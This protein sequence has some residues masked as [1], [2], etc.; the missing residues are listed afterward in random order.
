MVLDEAHRGIRSLFIGEARC[1]QPDTECASVGT[2]GAQGPDEG[3]E[4][5]TV[6]RTNSLCVSKAFPDVE[7]Q[8]WPQCEQLLPH[9]LVC[10]ELIEQYQLSST[11]A[12]YLLNQT[13]YLSQGTCSL[14]RSGTIVQASIG[15]REEQ[16]G[17]IAS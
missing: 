7:H 3:R 15:N 4:Q 12:A 1:D 2:S 8:N 10:S 11:E 13:G 16:L 17:A 6:G 14:S 5:E 9:A